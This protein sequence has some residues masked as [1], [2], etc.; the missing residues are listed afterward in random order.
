MGGKGD[1]SAAIGQLFPRISNVR[2]D[3]RPV[4]VFYDRAA[5][6][7]FQEGDIS[8]ADRFCTF[9]TKAKPSVA[10]IVAA[11]TTATTTRLVF[12]NLFA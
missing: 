12:R 2:D 6:N 1:N 4:I 3:T 8:S 7:C 9:N 10:V 11:P 5:L